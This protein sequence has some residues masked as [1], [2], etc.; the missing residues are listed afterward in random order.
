MSWEIFLFPV[1]KVSFGVKKG[2]LGN[3]AEE[4]RGRRESDYG[5]HDVV[6]G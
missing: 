6:L 3:T 2:L 1:K 4:N 5:F